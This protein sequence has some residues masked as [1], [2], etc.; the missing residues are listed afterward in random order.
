MLPI[1]QSFSGA[2]VT[3]RVEHKPAMWTDCRTGNLGILKAFKLHD[4]LFEPSS[5]AGP[6]Y[7]TKPQI[8]SVERFPGME[9]AVIHS[10]CITYDS[11]PHSAV[12]K[13]APS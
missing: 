12:G 3:K 2:A 11:I 1:V 13:A 4:S 5:S 7:D 10:V 6:P 8:L 9:L